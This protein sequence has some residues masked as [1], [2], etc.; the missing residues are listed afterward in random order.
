[1]LL[2]LLGVTPL[3]SSHRDWRPPR[4]EVLTVYIMLA[5]A[6]A[7]GATASSDHLSP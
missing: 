6:S 3:G 1:M 5:I 7:L 2:L 4:Q